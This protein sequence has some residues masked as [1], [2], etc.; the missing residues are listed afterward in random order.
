M[1]RQSAS[2]RSFRWCG[3][4]GETASLVELPEAF[5]FG[6]KE[7]KDSGMLISVEMRRRLRYRR[8]RWLSLGARVRRRP[9]VCRSGFRTRDVQDR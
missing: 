4:V 3:F 2:P 8:R 5:T 9:T 7:A 1:T 6:R